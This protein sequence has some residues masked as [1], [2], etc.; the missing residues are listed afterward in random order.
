MLPTFDSP[1]LEGLDGSNMRPGERV[2]GTSRQYVKFY[3]HKFQE[4]YATDTRIDT[5]TGE[6]KPIKFGTREVT[7]EMVHIVTPGDKNEY[8]GEATPWHKNEFWNQYTAFRQ[9]R[10]A[11]LGT[12][13]SEF[14]QFIN[15]HLEM[16]LK[17]LGC[18]TI[19][20]LADASDALCNQIPSGWELRE[21]AKALCK[22]KLEN[23]GKGEM[24][25]LKTQLEDSNKLIADMREEMERMKGMIVSGSELEKRRAGRPSKGGE[26]E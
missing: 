13:I 18:H 17:Y 8:D 12:P 2:R 3:T 16:E 22:T 25:A 26:A 20:Q 21:H 7:R 10:V 1:T 23:D 11:P 4:T 5:K 6:T 24:L 19:E 14:S 9:G 15:P